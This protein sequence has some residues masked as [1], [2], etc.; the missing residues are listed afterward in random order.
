MSNEDELLRLRDEAIGLRAQLDE[1]S[2]RLARAEAER[3]DAV[4]ELLVLSDSLDETKVDLRQIT[5][6]RDAL[7]ELRT[8]NNGLRRHIHA[9]HQS[10]TWK[11]GRFVLLPIRILRRI[12]RMITRG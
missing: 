7:L 6:E 3:S 12:K 10:R 8:E 11:I 5:R 2:H 9:M 1:A 4:R